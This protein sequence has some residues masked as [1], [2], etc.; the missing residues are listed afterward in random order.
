MS[1]TLVLIRA[2]IVITIIGCHG[3]PRKVFFLVFV[4][5][6]GPK[7]MSSFSYNEIVEKML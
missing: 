6:A 7:F 3:G 5:C 4:Q 1:L 2:T